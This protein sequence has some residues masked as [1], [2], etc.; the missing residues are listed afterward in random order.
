ME[1]WEPTLSTGPLLGIAVAAIAVILVSVIY[2]KLHAFLTLLVVS[3]LTALAA[4]IP[5]EG[6]VP[7][8]TQSFSSTLGSV[9]LLVGLGAMIGRLVEASGG[10]QSL[11]DAMVH[12]FG[13]NKAPLALGIASLIMGFPIFFDAGLI[14]M[15]PV[16]FAVARH[17]NGP[18]LAFGLPAAGA[19]SV[20]HVYLPPHPGPVA[21]SEFYGADLGLVLLV[22]LL[23]ALPTWY[24]SG[25][26]FGLFAGK[27]FSFKVTDAIAGPVLEK[28]EQPLKPAS[29]ATVVFILL[30]PMVLIFCNTGLNALTSYG[31]I[32][33][34]ATWVRFFVMLGQT[35]IAL[36]ITVLIALV[37]LGLRRSVEK[38]ALEKLVDS[39]LG[40][41]CSVV[42]ITGA[43]GMF[44]GV[45]RTSGIGDA[46][47]DSLSGLGI[48]VILACYLIAVALR[49]AQGSATVA[50]TTAAALMV[51][52]VEA[53]GFTELQ[54][55]LIVVAT[56][57]GSV[58]GSHVNDSGFWLVGRLM[59]MDTMT[60]LKT[61]T[62]N[63]M[64]IS[65]I[66]FALVLVLYGAAAVF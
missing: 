10:A 12:R 37:V 43:G 28:E 42:L 38:T 60:T 61:W 62:V 2:F 41:I 50:L 18:V 22:G 54:L 39:S 31:T 65:V 11:A 44:G 1:T 45:L 13:E 30:T 26:R 36:L 9:A 46:L 53:G 6:I 5:L 52:A 40:P 21:A 58:F 3:A 17:L 32:D 27:T 25:Y 8:M 19:F 34:G 35:P 16:I 64:L 57:A 51:P 49:L 47:A 20:M 33:A 23:L 7:T 66:G 15:L 29:A 59:G 56:A 4:G 24:I 48:P 14:V 63:Q 55:A